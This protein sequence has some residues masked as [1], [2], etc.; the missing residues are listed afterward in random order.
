M[1]MRRQI[2]RSVRQRE[3]GHRANSMLRVG[4]IADDLHT[5]LRAAA[6]ARWYRRNLRRDMRRAR[7]SA[8]RAARIRRRLVARFPELFAEKVVA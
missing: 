6:T 5:K 4:E 7:A 8:R 1:S 3:T 2:Q